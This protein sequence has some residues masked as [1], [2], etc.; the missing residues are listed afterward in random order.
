MSSSFSI[1]IPVFRE[2]DNIVPLIE[3]IAETV[4][5]DCEVIF[6]DDGSED[7]T[8]GVIEEVVR[9][10]PFVKAL[11][12]GRRYGKGMALLVG[13]D[14]ACFDT[15]ITLDGDLQNDPADIPKLLDALKEA[16]LVVGWRR[17]RRDSLSRRVQSA[18]YNL[19]LRLFAAS[20]LH[21]VNS[22]FRAFRKCIL[23]KPLLR[24]ERYR[25]F[26]L[27]THYAGFAV[28]EVVVQHLP[29]HSGE[30]KY[31]FSRIFSALSDI[32]SADAVRYRIETE[33]TGG[34]KPERGLFTSRLVSKK[35]SLTTKYIV[36]TVLL[37]L[38]L[39]ICFLLVWRRQV[40]F[41]WYYY[42]LLA[43]GIFGFFLSLLL[44]FTSLRA[45][46][47]LTSTKPVKPTR[48]LPE[49]KG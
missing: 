14:A 42:L 18:F 38:L 30:S 12:L 22:G 29:R 17:R 27:V 21:D 46:T 3:R 49:E 33:E 36:M 1:V 16:H 23:E 37:V 13:Y 40:H 7:G 28:K 10:Y 8:E 5:A 31:G 32:F 47:V 15:I 24:N 2:R 9:K 4:G 44:T 34:V 48:I 6:V 45:E 25:I 43:V 35:V 20:P 39:F 41:F 11:F 19:A 26:P